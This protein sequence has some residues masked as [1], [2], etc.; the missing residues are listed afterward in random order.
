MG[1]EQAILLMF[2]G[3]LDSTA[4][5]YKLLTEPEHSEYKIQ[6]HH[7]DLINVENRWRAESIAVKKIIEEISSYG[8]F[9]YTSSTH[10]YLK[11]HRIVPDM[12]W[13]RFMAGMLVHNDHSIKKIAVGR[14]K[15]DTESSRNLYPENVRQADMLY[16]S[17]IS[18]C[19]NVSTEF[20]FPVI[21]MSK[22]Q[23]WDFLPPN[24]RDLTWSCRFPIYTSS[25]LI[26]C[27]DC[28]AC[29]ALAKIEEPKCQEN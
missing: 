5:F 21:H 22:Q 3:G 25:G 4:V 14:T 23:I 17:V 29:N 18:N 16:N 15:E 6:V 19:K 8:D 12:Y 11:L 28:I 2:S 9:T 24:I 27:E 20:I 10:E 7:M 26:P 1:K 13:Y